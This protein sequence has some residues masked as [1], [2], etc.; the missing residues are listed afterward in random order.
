MIQRMGMF[1]EYLPALG[2]A[3]VVSVKS[4]ILAKALPVFEG[5]GPEIF[6]EF[7]DDGTGLLFPAHGSLVDGRKRGWGSNPGGLRPGELLR[8]LGVVKSL[9]FVLLEQH[10]IQGQSPDPAWPRKRKDGGVLCD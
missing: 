8:L 6:V 10:R 1:L 4:D 5:P 3:A 2:D 9:G 7:A